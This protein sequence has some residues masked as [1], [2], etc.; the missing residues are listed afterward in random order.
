ML[1]LDNRRMVLASVAALAIAMPRIAIGET[2]AHELNTPFVT[3]MENP[4]TGEVVVI[5]GNLDIIV[6]STPDTSGGFH[7]KIHMASKGTGVA[8]GSFTQ[9]VFSEEF[10]SELTSAGA[11]TQTQTL[12][13]FLT[14]AGAS[15]NSFFKMTL[16]FTLNGTGVPTVD[17]G[18]IEGGCRG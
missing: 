2:T 17:V 12:N 18:N 4:C 7:N 13:H 1:K 14:S 9:Y 3:T 11:T 10:D 8:A 16:H 15:D 6:H 5:D